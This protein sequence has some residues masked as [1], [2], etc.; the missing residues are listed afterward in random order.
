MQS[1]PAVALPLRAAIRISA[2][3]AVI[4]HPLE[5]VRLLS[6]QKGVP[7]VLVPEEA[8]ER[9]AA[10]S[11]PQRELAAPAA[12]ARDAVV[13][14][15]VAPRDQHLM[16]EMAARPAAA[17]AAAEV[18]ASAAVG[19]RAC[20]AALEAITAAAAVVPAATARAE[21]QAL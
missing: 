11:A 5:A 8:V 20:M 12:L 18:L 1:A 2:L 19:V 21:A 15:V 13:V 3:Q 16:A 9:Q 7:G 6:A 4:V 14:V 17:R 10:V